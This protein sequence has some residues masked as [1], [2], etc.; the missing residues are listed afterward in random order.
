M[1]NARN[2]ANLLGTNT[3]IQTADIDDGAFQANKNLIINGAMQVAQRGTSYSQ[4]PNSG[5]FHTVDR[6]SYRRN[7]T[8]S[9]V[10]AVTLTQ[11]SSGAPEGFKNFLRYAPV[12]SDATTPDDAT[13]KLNT[14]C[15]GL[16]AAHLEWGT[17]NAKT[18]T[19]SFY[20]RSTVTG[21]FNVSFADD[22][23][24]ANRTHQIQEYTINSANTW[25][26]KTLTF[27]GP[28]SGTWPVD[29]GKIFQI[30]WVI[31]G[32]NTGGGSV[33]VVSPN[34]WSVPGTGTVIT[35]NQTDGV[36]TSSGQTWDI[37][38]IQLELGSQATPF[39]HR[40]FGDELAR[41]QRYYV[42]QESVYGSYHTFGFGTWFSATRFIGYVQMPV[43]MRTNPSLAV[44][45]SV[46]AW[47]GV[48]PRGT[49]SGSIGI[50]SVGGNGSPTIIEIDVTSGLSG[51]S[52][53]SHGFLKADNDS[54][55]LLEFNAE[56]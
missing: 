15:E 23:S 37:T 42:K 22:E 31:S 21:T 19:L 1:S 40:S 12:G 35:S 6:F 7:G 9:G 8:W 39:E 24:S 28:T 47:Q 3:Q 2:L 55:A 14:K 44:S 32:D 50:S 26:R 48:I 46:A 29:N 4:S 17:S 18:V 10:T 5:G 56:L 54:S 27:S 53:G 51:S 25:E 11:E 38:G 16:N 20:V 52:A 34:T 45:G 41:C 43:P 13:I 33:S 36:T 49:I 30:D